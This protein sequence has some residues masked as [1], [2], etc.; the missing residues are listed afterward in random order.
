[1]I[2]KTSTK[3]QLLFE[4]LYIKIAQLLIKYKIETLSNGEFLFFAKHGCSNIIDFLLKQNII[5]PSQINNYAVKI[6]FQNGHSNI[7]NTLFK[8]KKVKDKLFLFDQELFL[9]LKQQNISNKAKAF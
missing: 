2:P 7:A 1:M 3:P 6:A 4:L 5:D 8:E 9:H